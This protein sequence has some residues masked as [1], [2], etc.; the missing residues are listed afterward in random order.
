MWHVA[1]RRLVRVRDEDRSWLY[2]LLL[3]MMEMN[4]DIIFSSLTT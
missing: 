1:V 3:L 2:S 4:N